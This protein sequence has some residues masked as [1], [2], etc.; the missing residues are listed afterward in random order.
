[1]VTKNTDLNVIGDLRSTPEAFMSAAGRLGIGLL[2]DAISGTGR[3]DRYHV[4]SAVSDF[5]SMAFP[6]WQHLLRE[7]A[8]VAATCAWTYPEILVANPVREIAPIRTVM[9]TA[10]DSG[11]EYDLILPTV[12]VGTIAEL[13]SLVTHALYDQENIHYRHILVLSPLAQRDAEKEFKACLPEGFAEI[14]VWRQYLPQTRLQ[15]DGTL[16]PGIGARSYARVGFDTVEDTFEYLPDA[17]LSRVSTDLRRN[18]RHR[19]PGP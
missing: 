15:L 6:L 9:R 11:Y 3:A 18:P 10:I 12:S 16:F 1:M 8:E 19:P 17:F 2:R 7:G 4:V 13:K 14:V 5:D